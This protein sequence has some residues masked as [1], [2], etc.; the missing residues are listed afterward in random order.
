MMGSMTLTL[1]PA[2]AA[3]CGA[4]MQHPADNLVVPAS[5][6]RGNS[7][8]NVADVG[9]VQIQPDAL[10]QVMNIVFGQTCAGRTDLSAGVALLDASDQRIVGASSDVRV[11]GDHLMGLHGDLLNQG[12]DL[13]RNNICSDSVP[14]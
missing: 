9:T 4:H 11:G 3:S 14:D 13:P 2:E 6:A 1:L 5:A 7:A 8:R 12:Q 10:R